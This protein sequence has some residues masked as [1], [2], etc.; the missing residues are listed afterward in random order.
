ME[1]PASIPVTAG[2][3]TANTI[4]KPLGASSAG[5]GVSAGSGE[6]S[7]KEPSEATITAKI[8]SCVRSA[9]SVER[10]ASRVSTTSAA[11]PISTAE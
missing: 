6:P 2:K 10:K 9:S 7:R 5:T 8:S 3:N 1:M 11:S 4:Q